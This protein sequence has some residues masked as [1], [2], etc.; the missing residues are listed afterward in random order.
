MNIR[1]IRRDYETAWRAYLLAD[2]DLCLD[3]VADLPEERAQFLH[4]R[5]LLRLGRPN[6]AVG[7]LRFEAEDESQRRALM[8][9]ALGRCG[10]YEIATEEL[11]VAGELAKSSQARAQAAFFA[12]F[13]EWMLGDFDAAE[14]QLPRHGADPYL[15][16]TID[17]LRGWIAV[18]RRDFKTALKWFMSAFEAESR[19][20]DDADRYVLARLAYS[21]LAIVREFSHTPIAGQIESTLEGVEWTPSMQLSRFHIL[22]HLAWVVAIEGNFSDTFRYLRH[23][24][25]IAPSE[26]W[27]VSILCDIAYLALSVGEKRWSDNVAD[28]ARDIAGVVDWASTQHEE[29]KGILFLAQIEANR[30][31]ARAQERMATYDSLP[32]PPPTISRDIRDT[33]L[34]AFVRGCVSHAVGDTATA[35]FQY[36]QAFDIYHEIGFQ[37]RAILCSLA[38]GEVSHRREHFEY[39]ALQLRTFPNSWLRLRVADTIAVY[40]NPISVRFT[41]AQLEVLQGLCE[42]KTYREIGEQTGR[43]TATVRDH[44]KEIRKITH[45]KNRSELIVYCVRNGLMVNPS[46]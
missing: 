24:R 29:R 46:Q 7:V 27:R 35:A 44:L 9:T 5:V 6:E 17:D 23:A 4:A 39:A 26:A 28:E 34:E 19:R 20:G 25:D 12:A 8:G 30:D 33:A 43:S 11:R 42:G 3:I 40:E 18:G 16:V 31:P 10:M 21:A 2:Y 22:R 41:P 32:E 14:A 45:T 38:R 13:H 36:G 1:A 37:W 15:A